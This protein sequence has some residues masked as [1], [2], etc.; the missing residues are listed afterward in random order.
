[1]PWR[2]TRLL[3]ARMLDD[4]LSRFR[5]IVGYVAGT[6]FCIGALYALIVHGPSLWRDASNRVSEFRLRFV[7]GRILLIIM[8]IND[9]KN[10]LTMQNF[11]LTDGMEDDDRTRIVNGS[12]DGCK[13]LYGDDKTRCLT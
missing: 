7:E 12:L 3:G 2:N 4:R 11:Q 13:K 1:P 9:A 8:N 5:D 10:A 6:A